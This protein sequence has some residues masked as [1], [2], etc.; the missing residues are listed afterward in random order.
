[1]EIKCELVAVDELIGV[2]RDGIEENYNS[3]DEWD[4]IALTILRKYCPRIE[5]EVENRGINKILCDVAAM[6]GCSVEE[7]QKKWKALTD[8]IIEY[9]KANDKLSKEENHAKT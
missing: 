8:A 1:M 9:T 3:K 7:L 2:I 5:V 6:S 4:F